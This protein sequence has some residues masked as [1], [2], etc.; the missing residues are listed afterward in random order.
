[1]IKAKHAGADIGL[2]Y[3][4]SERSFNVL[5]KTDDTKK[6]Q[7]YE[8]VFEKIASFKPIKESFNTMKEVLLQELNGAWLVDPF[9]AVAKLKSMVIDPTK[10]DPNE[11]RDAGISVKWEHFEIFCKNLLE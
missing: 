3:Q 11:I 4:V 5:F 2:T 6:F 1:M 10:K 8:E 7:L 9:I